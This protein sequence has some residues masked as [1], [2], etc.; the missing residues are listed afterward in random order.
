MLRE[1]SGRSESNLE[2]DRCAGLC[3]CMAKDLPTSDSLAPSEAQSAASAGKLPLPSNTVTYNGEAVTY[4][5][6]PVTYGGEPVTSGDDP[7][8]RPAGPAPGV[9]EDGLNWVDNGGQYLVDTGEAGQLRGTG[10]ALHVSA[11]TWTGI[12]ST[13]EQAEIVR[14]LVPN[15]MSGI[16]SIIDDI[17]A[18][19]PNDNT[20]LND[21]RALH[22][23]LG[24]LIAAADYD[25]G[26]TSL[27]ELTGKSLS[28][29]SRILGSS[30]NA[31]SA[32]TRSPT[33]TMGVLGCLGYLFHVDL[34][35]AVF[36]GI[37]SGFIKT[38]RPA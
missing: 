6:E 14:L 27:R 30:D 12:R 16:E 19:R 5:G 18:S 22:A 20:T 11:S 7:R 10:T 31:F 36:S 2:H 29:L 33:M 3:A 21:L 24:E 28:V 35:T 15:A 23:A 37:V 17:A 26:G 8:E 38:Q 4:G 1:D 25:D 32:V 9:D 34:T 13:A